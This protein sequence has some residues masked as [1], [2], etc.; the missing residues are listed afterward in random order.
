MAIL[1]LHLYEHLLGE[2][3]FSIFIIVQLVCTFIHCYSMYV[4]YSYTIA[5]CVLLLAIVTFEPSQHHCT[6][7]TA[8]GV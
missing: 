2:K 1:C 8:A 6:K 4:C 3:N 5:F 7:I